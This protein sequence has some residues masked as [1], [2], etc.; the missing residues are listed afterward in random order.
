[1]QIGPKSTT[2]TCLDFTF[3]RT[4]DEVKLSNE[5]IYRWISLNGINGDYR[6]AIRYFGKSEIPATSGWH[7]ICAKFQE[8]NIE[9]VKP[10]EYGSATHLLIIDYNSK[11]LSNWPKLP[12][13]NR[14]LTATEPVSVNPLQFNEKVTSK[15]HKVIVPSKL[16]PQSENSV[17]YEGGY[18][19]LARYSR[20]HTNDGTRIGCGLINENKFS[21]AKQSNYILRTKFIREALNSGLALKIAGRNWDRGLIWTISKLVHHFLIALRAKHIHLR[22]TDILDAVNFSLIQR[23]IRKINFGVVPDNVEFLARFKVAIV[24]ENESSYVS[25]KLHAALMAGCQCV[26]V[27]PRLN[28]I[29]FPKGFLFQSDPNPESILQ[30]AKVALSTAYSIS[31]REL[32]ESIRQSEFFHSYGVERRNSWI[33]KSIFN[34]IKP[35]L[36]V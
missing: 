34:W 26:Y 32:E 30:N 9:V 23:S 6:L 21:F 1:M 12:K 13:R 7:S 11:D 5:G 16:S 20:A 25:E 14:F 27:G 2:K 33:A 19:N 22:F 31:S 28:P 4:E 29:H 10:E 36:G 18:M 17:V 3:S 15:F 24:I 8:L 35:D